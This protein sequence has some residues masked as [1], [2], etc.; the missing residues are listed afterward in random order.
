MTRSHRHRSTMAATTT[1][2]IT[3][4]L[5]FMSS[6]AVLVIA[7]SS[8]IPIEM[9]PTDAAAASGAASASAVDGSNSG[10]CPGVKWKGGKQ[11]VE[12]RHR[13]LITLPSNVDPQTQV[14][15][16][17]GS[18]L[19]TLPRDA[20]VRA[21]LLNLQKIYLA[22]CRI[23]HLDATALR[24]L[25]NLVEL[26]LSDNL[27]TDVPGA[28]L[29]DAPSLRELRLSSNPIQKVETRAFD[30][31][32][33]LIKLDLSDCRIESLAPGAF[34]GIDQLSHLR[35]QDNR[36]QEMQPDVVSSLPA[37]LHGLELAGNP[38]ICDCRNRF[39]RQWLHQHNVPSPAT[40]LCASPAR[41]AGRP[42]VDL[43]PDDF[44][45]APHVIVLLQSATAP[46]HQPP[47]HSTSVTGP[48]APLQTGQNDWANSAKSHYMHVEASAGENATLTC[49]M[50]GVP[51][52][53]IAWLWR[54]RPMN[55]G[56]LV[57]ADDP[58]VALGHSTFDFDTS[59]AS[60]PHASSPGIAD[61]PRTVV[62]V[63]EGKYEKTSRL[64]L[65]PARLIDTGE[66]VC[67]KPFFK[68][69][70]SFKS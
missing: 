57:P 2:S 13:A 41:L 45:C 37:R 32:P 40:A 15:D 51:A 46:P 62:I 70:I 47:S 31:A 14:L 21:N 55:N 38:W 30:S 19:Q 61:D 64:I 28:A 16:L 25:T 6:S 63:E 17:T 10:A 65:S 22:S 29:R 33:S 69:K 7:S 39:L 42:L 5:L 43:Q 44:A 56:S 12:C 67:G 8:S 60:A 11:T 20:F 9:T 3:F 36:L 34:D 54:G 52:P 50:S 24:G 35:L 18:N 27:L 58:D 4:L 66:Y 26:D 49:R 48:A 59:T 68:L 1:A 53:E 23:G